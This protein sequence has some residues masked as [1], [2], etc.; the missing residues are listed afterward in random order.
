MDVDDS[1]LAEVRWHLGIGPQPDAADL[2]AGPLFGPEGAGYLPGGDISR[3]DREVRSG[4][5]GPVSGWGVF[6]RR[7]MLDDELHELLTPICDWLAAVAI[8]GYAGFW[9][10][11]DE[12]AL[13]V[14]IVRQGHTYMST[15]SGESGPATFGAPPKANQ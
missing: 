15:Q 9:R 3:L 1:D 2:T 13:N 4:D 8:D 14:L 7:F 6:V 12:T 10:E 11:E 5:G